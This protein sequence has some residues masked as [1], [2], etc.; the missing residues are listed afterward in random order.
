MLLELFDARRP[1]VPMRV[2]LPLLPLPW[3]FGRFAAA[4]PPLHSLRA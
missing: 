4:S 2:P 1:F 3:P